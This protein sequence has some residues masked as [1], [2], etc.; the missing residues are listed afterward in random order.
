MMEVSNCFPL[1]AF[2]EEEDKAAKSVA[3]GMLRASPET[4]Y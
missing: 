2:A 1:P 4:L 3:Q